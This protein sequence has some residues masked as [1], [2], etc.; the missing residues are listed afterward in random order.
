MNIGHIEMSPTEALFRTPEYQA[1]S[2]RIDAAA[3]C[4][5]LLRVAVDYAPP[6]AMPHLTMALAAA[7]GA[8]HGYH[9]R[10]DELYL[11]AIAGREEIVQ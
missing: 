5:D 9:Y 2:R 8:Y 7:E 11:S 10:D 1:N 6:H 4:L 3:K